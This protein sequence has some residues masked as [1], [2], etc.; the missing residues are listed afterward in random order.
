MTRPGRF[1]RKIKISLPDVFARVNIIK[2]HLRQKN[3]ALSDYD[4][5]RVATFLDGCSGAEIENLVNQ[6][7]LQTVR[8]ARK[9]RVRNPCIRMPDFEK[10]VESF[11]RE[12]I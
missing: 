2:I 12:R 9:D 10:A 6:A 3:H 8:Q 7:A 5:S 4:I 11:K 1:D